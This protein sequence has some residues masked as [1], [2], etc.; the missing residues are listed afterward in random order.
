MTIEILRSHS[1][2]LLQFQPGLIEGAGLGGGR[3]ET[4]SARG[5]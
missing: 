2:A 4:E 3:G 5:L 1:G